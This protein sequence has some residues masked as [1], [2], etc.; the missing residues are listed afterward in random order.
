MANT[1]LIASVTG[2]AVS[3]IVGPSA[4]AWASLHSVRTAR[5]IEVPRLKARAP[6]ALGDCFAVT[7]ATATLIER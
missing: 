2:I 3:G 1:T 4:T 6:I 5:M 7:T